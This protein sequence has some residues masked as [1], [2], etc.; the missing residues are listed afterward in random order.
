[1]IAEDERTPKPCGRG[2][3]R[4]DQVG[5]PTL[6]W[7]C[8]HRADR[9]ADAC[10]CAGRSDPQ[11]VGAWSFYTHHIRTF[12]HALGTVRMEP[13]RRRPRSMSG[14]ASAASTTS[15]R[16]RQR[17]ADSGAVNPSL[18]IAAVALRS[19]DQLVHEESP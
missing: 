9:S 1:V 10:S 17:A 4:S 15:S 5:L 7:A 2:L 13:I 19:M 6:A 14:A 8:L 18:T 16:R 11:G 3:D 12:S